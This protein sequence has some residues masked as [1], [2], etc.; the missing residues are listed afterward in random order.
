MVCMKEVE[1]DWYTAKMPRVGIVETISDGSNEKNGR[2]LPVRTCGV[3][4]ELKS[5]LWRFEKYPMD[6]CLDSQT[7][8]YSAIPYS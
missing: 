6:L 5:H 3:N 1:L 8:G 4:K 2:I 7:E